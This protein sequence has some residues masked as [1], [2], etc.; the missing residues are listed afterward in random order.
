[1]TVYNYYHVDLT[2]SISELLIYLWILDVH[3]KAKNHSKQGVTDIP[4][5]ISVLVKLSI[6]VIK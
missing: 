6:A 3:F 5:I 1:M 2:D 4:N